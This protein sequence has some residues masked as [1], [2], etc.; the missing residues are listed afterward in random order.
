MNRCDATSSKCVRQDCS[1][2]S[3]C[4]MTDKNGSS[5]FDVCNGSYC[6]RSVSCDNTGADCSG[7]QKGANT[8]NQCNGGSCNY[9]TTCSS[10]SQCSNV[11]DTQG[12]VLNRCDNTTG[13]CARTD[14]TSN[15]VCTASGKSAQIARLL[16]TLEA[17]EKVSVGVGG[18]AVA[19]NK[20]N[21]TYCVPTLNCSKGSDCAGAIDQSG[22]NANICNGSVCIASIT[23]SNSAGCESV[24][25]QSLDNL[26]INICRTEDG[27]NTCTVQKCT[28]SSECSMTDK[29]NTPFD[30]CIDGRCVA[31]QSCSSG[32]D[33][34]G[35]QK[36]D[37]TALYHCDGSKCVEKVS[38]SNSS[39]CNN[40]TDSNNKKLNRCSSGFCANQSC[41]QGSECTQSDDA[42]VAFDKCDVSS[43]ICYDEITCSTSSSCNGSDKNNLALNMCKSSKCQNKT[44]ANGSECTLSD[45]SNKQFDECQSG[46][47]YET[48][49][50]SKGSDC[51]GVTRRNGSG[52]LDLS[53]CDGSNC[54]DKVSCSSSSQC[55]SVQTIDNN[56]LNFCKTDSGSNKVCSNHVCTKGDDCK[57]IKD[58]GDVFIDKCNGSFCFSDISCGQQNVCSGNERVG[59]YPLTHCLSSR[60]KSP[61]TCQ[62]NGDCS[63]YDDKGIPLNRCLGGVCQGQKCVDGYDCDGYLDFA[64]RV[65]DKCYNGACVHQVSCS[66]SSQC[67]NVI[68]NQGRR[69][70]RCENSVCS[71]AQ[72]CSSGPDCSRCDTSNTFF[73]VCDGK[74]CWDY[75]S[76]SDGKDCKNVTNKSGAALNYCNRASYPYK[77]TDDINCSSSN[78]CNGITDTAGQIVNICENKVCVTQTCTTSAEC[79]KTDVNGNKFD[80]CRM[81]FCMQAY[82]CGNSNQC[83]GVVDNDGNPTPNCTNNKCTRQACTTQTEC[84]QT[85]GQSVL[86]DQCNGKSCFDRIHCITGADCTEAKDASGAS[87]AICVRGTCKASAACTKDDDCGGVFDANKMWLNRCDGSKCVSQ[88]CTVGTECTDPVFNKCEGRICMKEIP[89]KSSADCVGK[90]DA[91]GKLLNRCSDDE[92]CT[93]QTCSAG[94][95]CTEKDRTG[96]VDFNVCNTAQGLCFAKTCTAGSQCTNLQNRHGLALNTCDIAA[97]TCIRD[98]ACDT[99]TDCEGLKGL[100]DEVLTCTTRKVCGH[101]QDSDDIEKEGATFASLASFI[102]V[103]VTLFLF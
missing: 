68:N 50:C 19:H 91:Q 1:S 92:V 30:I 25:D 29:D 13:K 18:S 2:G 54:T 63:G 74:E 89:C 90:T 45:D 96:K 70:N 55:S 37:G 20:C 15:T 14:C 39:A 60:C 97:N 94:S 46:L 6:V 58:V 7:V 35:V 62:D 41:S 59:G 64:G 83:R 57:G 86:F 12:K 21:G 61:V 26:R 27:N 95:Y 10:D 99:N 78:E 43:K 11:F 81:G 33:C 4:T 71:L 103:F 5:Q 98:K 47:C 69:L 36:A 82:S 76:C 65:F 84:T 8:M 72:E 17:K 22:K 66:A 88:T 67:T 56:P 44:C 87:L 53:V 38:C 100:N 49:E 75:I 42:S 3:D 40:A 24:N 16:A 31:E 34:R 23:C 101:E 79:T 51:S 73:H 80:T 48:I 52:S 93:H 32:F 77:C 85:D 9:D 102:T 28:T